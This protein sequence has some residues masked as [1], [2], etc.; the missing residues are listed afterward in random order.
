MQFCKG[1]LTDMFVF[2]FIAVHFYSKLRLYW[3]QAL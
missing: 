1:D 2:L 3:C